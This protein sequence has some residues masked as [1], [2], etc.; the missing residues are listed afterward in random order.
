MINRSEDATGILLLSPYVQGKENYER[1][2]DFACSRKGQGAPGAR[3]SE[4]SGAD[5]GISPDR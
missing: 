4:G 1:E 3:A 2:R 5:Q